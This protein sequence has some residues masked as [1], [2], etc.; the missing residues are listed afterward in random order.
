MPHARSS[1]CD[2]STA[3]CFADRL[4]P[5]DC[6]AI[7]DT[8][9]AGGPQRRFRRAHSPQSGRC[10]VLVRRATTLPV[11][12][13]AP[14]PWLSAGT[15]PRRVESFPGVGGPGAG[16]ARAL[17]GVG[18]GLWRDCGMPA[19]KRNLKNLTLKN[20]PQEIQVTSL[21]QLSP[22]RNS[23]AEEPEQGEAVLA[24]G[25]DRGPHPRR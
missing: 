3:L 21:N 17:A 5:M 11:S 13:S 4:C 24:S 12:V 15:A 6:P 9:A 23:G 1:R 2:L 25:V 8:S 19:G 14:E 10:A 16:E 18:G 20:Q 22:H 7:E